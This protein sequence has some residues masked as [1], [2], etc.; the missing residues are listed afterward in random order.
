[1]GLQATRRRNPY[2]ANAQQ[3][4]SNRA[5]RLLCLRHPKF[6]NS[7]CS[8]RAAQGRS[9]ALSE[10]ALSAPIRRPRIVM[11]GL[12]SSVSALPPHLTAE[13][14]PSA[15]QRQGVEMTWNQQRRQV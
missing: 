6:Q 10:S 15:Q 4:C 12:P 13:K 7:R 14:L 5:V 3:I 2:T 1:L 11:F 8:V 9:L